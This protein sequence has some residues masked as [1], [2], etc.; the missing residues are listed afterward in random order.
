MSD[1]L[2]KINAE[3]NA[4]TIRQIHVPEWDMVLHVSPITVLQYS[5]INKETNVVVRAVRVIQIRAKNE[6]GLPL[7]DEN[8][9]NEVCSKGVGK[10]GIDVLMR[11]AAEI[12]E[13]VPV[14]EDVEKN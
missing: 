13:D 11:V 1:M 10:F 2:S 12:V 8:W 3:W 5:L 9:F 14:A 7:F 6:A 4:R